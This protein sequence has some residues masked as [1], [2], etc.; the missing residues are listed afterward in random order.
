MYLCPDSF[1]FVPL[2]ISQT[3]SET[4]KCRTA[5]A[6]LKAVVPAMV[7]PNEAGNIRRAKKLNRLRWERESLYIER[8]LLRRLFMTS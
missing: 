3:R 7:E 8:R 6:E 4:L 2:L 1:K 5:Y